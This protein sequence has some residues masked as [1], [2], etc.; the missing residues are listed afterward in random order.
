MRRFCLNE[1]PQLINLLKGDLKWVGVIPVSQRNFQ[2]IPKEMQKLRLT[3]KP[4]CVPPYVALNREGNV[5][6]V[7][8]GDI[9]MMFI[10]V[11]MQFAHIL[12]LEKKLVMQVF[13]V[14]VLLMHR[15][16][17]PPRVLNH[18][19]LKMNTIPL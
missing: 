8:L 3:Q 14:K 17:H 9:V 7:F 11:V 13:V 6:S 1:S 12:L 19:I 16:M 5:M 4:G 10:A 15:K 18:V 2:D